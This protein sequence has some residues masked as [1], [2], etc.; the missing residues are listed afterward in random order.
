MLTHL[1]FRRTVWSRL[2]DRYPALMKSPKYRQLFGYLLTARRDEDTGNIPLSAGTVS[3]VYAH[4]AQAARDR[5]V[6]VTRDI[7]ILESL[8]GCRIELS[9][10]D[11]HGHR[12]RE[13][14]LFQLSREMADTLYPA[15]APDLLREGWVNLVDGKLLP[16]QAR[17]AAAADLLAEIDEVNAMLEMPDEQRATL[18]YLN[19]ELGPVDYRIRQSDRS[20]AYAYVQCLD[21]PAQQSWAYNALGRIDAWPH[22][23]YTLS[24]RGRSS[25]I[26]GAGL[27]WPNLP[28]AL[29]RLLRPDWLEF[30]LA[31]AH[32]AIF[33]ALTGCQSLLD[34]LESGV[35][36]WPWLVEHAGLEYDDDTKAVVKILVYEMIFGCLA[37]NLFVP[38]GAL[39]PHLLD[40]WTEDVQQRFLGLP[41]IQSILAAR[42]G[43]YR[44]IRRQG[45]LVCPWTGEFVPTV[46]LAGESVAPKSVLSTVCQLAEWELLRPFR[47]ATLTEGHREHG[48]TMPVFQHDGASVKVK[49]TR[50]TDDVIDRLTSV[51]NRHV[52]QLGICT[53]LTVERAARIAG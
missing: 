9:K 41:L 37:H 19:H 25:R 26:F 3:R 21:D 13:V 27:G 4:D 39:T 38:K 50:D 30:D 36:P 8:T 44:G 34:F 10:Y 11:H 15:D 16:R 49:Y 29:R 32:L 31:N 51:T 12:G 35:K 33:A 43:S 20:A 1:H 7:D 17:A 22:V 45:G 47:E 23:P 52:A 14:W 6:C 18:E 53:R 48:W 40:R 46:D 28:K 2:M 42:R 5:H 24:R